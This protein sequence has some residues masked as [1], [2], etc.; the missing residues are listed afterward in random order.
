MEN[1]IMR[2]AVGNGDITFVCD[3]TEYVRLSKNNS[4]IVFAIEYRD[5]ETAAREILGM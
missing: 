2:I 5:A 4:R 3:R 1:I